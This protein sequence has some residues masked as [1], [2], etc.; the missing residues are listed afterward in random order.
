MLYCFDIEDIKTEDDAKV[1]AKGLRTEVIQVTNHVGRGKSQKIRA[2]QSKL[3]QFCALC[4]DES[5]SEAK[6]I[7][8]K[9]IDRIEEAN[10][11]YTANLYYL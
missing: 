8:M 4:H 6:K 7:V 11:E 2:T 10:R 1:V 5:W 9:S 3:K